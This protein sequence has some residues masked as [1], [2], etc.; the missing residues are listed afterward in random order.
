M[1]K[2]AQIL[3]ADWRR[4]YNSLR[5]HSWLGQRPLV[6]ETIAFPA[7]RSLTTGRRN[8]CR[9]WL[10]DYRGKRTDERCPVRPIVG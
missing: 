10:W 3:I 2:E 4:L 8:L 9:R 7:S 1:L 5:P 6:P